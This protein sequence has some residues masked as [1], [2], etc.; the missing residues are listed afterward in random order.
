MNKSSEPVSVS[1]TAMNHFLRKKKSMES[2]ALAR[3]EYQGRAMA[4]PQTRSYTLH[5]L[6]R[7]AFDD[8][9]APLVAKD[10]TGATITK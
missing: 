7:S 6:N 9:S 3:A 5:A 8:G 4:R 2:A 10:K 1:D